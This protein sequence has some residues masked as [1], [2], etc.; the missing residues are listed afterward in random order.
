MRVGR[1]PVQQLHGLHSAVRI[2]RLHPHILPHVLLCGRLSGA[3][4]WLRCQASCF[5][6][7]SCAGLTSLIW[8]SRG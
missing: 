6:L 8:T 3:A 1:L 5:G 4:V 7:H 2:T